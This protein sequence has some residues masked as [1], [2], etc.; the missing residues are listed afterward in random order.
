MAAALREGRPYSSD[1][2]IILPSGTERNIHAQAKILY[3]AKTK[4]P[5]KIKDHA[6]SAA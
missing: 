1:Y 2:R 3:D 5:S 4:R 6:F